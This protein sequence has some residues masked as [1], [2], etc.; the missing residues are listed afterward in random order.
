MK[1]IKRVHF[2]DGVRTATP[3]RINSRRVAHILINS[4]RRSTQ[5]TTSTSPALSLC[6]VVGA[7]GVR[8]VNGSQRIALVRA[9]Q[10]ASV[11]KLAPTAPETPRGDASPTVPRSPSGSC[12]RPPAC[13]RL[14]GPKG[15]RAVGRA[16][17]CPFRLFASPN[18]LVI[19]L[20]AISRNDLG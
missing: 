16:T 13:C 8:G 20:D 7:N 3:R 1:V 11:Q 19:E 2:D 12:V 15:S 10:L 17:S 4:A 6:P 18:D 5:R 14:L 9:W